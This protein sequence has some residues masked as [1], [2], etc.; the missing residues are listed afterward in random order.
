MCRR[1]YKHRGSDCNCAQYSKGIE[2][3]GGGSLNVCLWEP[4]LGPSVS[5]AVTGIPC[6]RPVIKREDCFGSISAT[7]RGQ[8]SPTEATG[9]ASNRE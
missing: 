1:F 8:K 7:C 2:T 3:S 9:P 6:G 4:G 5:R